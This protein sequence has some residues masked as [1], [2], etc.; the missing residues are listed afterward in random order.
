M[1]EVLS[2][3]LNR[4]S[5]LGYVVESSSSST[6]RHEEQIQFTP[7]KI[8]G[9]LRKEVVRGVAASKCASACWT[10]GEVFT[11]GT[12]N[13]Q[14]G[15]YIT[16]RY[17]AFE[18]KLTVSFLLQGYDKAAHPIQ[19][20]PKKITKVNQPVISIALSV[21]ILLFI[22][23]GRTLI[24]NRTQRWLVCFGTNKSNVSGTT[25]TTESSTPTPFFFLRLPH[26]HLIHPAFQHKPSRPRSS[27]TDPLKPSKTHTYQK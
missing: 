7:K 3:G 11:W 6:A 21:G 4:F 1:G 22:L 27:P 12:N 23:S 24:F 10:E 26:T 8:Y 15:V 18:R 19:V 20:L 17:R 9:Q 14:L 5:Q 16:M 13:G 25:D 2:W